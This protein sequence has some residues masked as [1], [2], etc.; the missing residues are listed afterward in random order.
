[1]TAT[2]APRLHHVVFCTFPDSQDRAATFW[3]ELG[4]VF[5]D[6]GLPE[7]GLRVLI[8]WQAGIEIVSPTALDSPEAA[9]F[10]TFLHERGEGVYS[11]VVAVSE[12]EEPSAIAARYGAAVLYQQHREFGEYQLDEAMHAPVHGMPV[13]F[14]ATRTTG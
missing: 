13:T 3:R 6:I 7:L 4:L 10:T 8:D 12:V 14:L 9:S 11:V 5:Q 2:P 1:M